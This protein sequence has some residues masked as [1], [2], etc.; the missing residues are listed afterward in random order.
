MCYLHAMTILF[1]DEELKRVCTKYLTEQW[2]RRRSQL[3]P[4]RCNQRVPQQAR[5]RH[6]PHPA[7]YWRDR[8]RNLRRL[9]VGHIPDQPPLPILRVDA[10]D[11]DIDHRRTRLGPVAADHLGV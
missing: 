10:V 1:S 2:E 4:S 6:R 5:D 9:L 3:G 11:A 7:R 8:A